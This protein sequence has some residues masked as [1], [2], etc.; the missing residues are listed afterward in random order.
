M[1]R[2]NV[3]SLLFWTVLLLTVNAFAAHSVHYWTLYDKSQDNMGNTVCSWV[4]NQ[5]NETHTVVTSGRG[6]FCPRPG[7]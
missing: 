5:M 7:L 6:N 4:C 2:R 1:K 3:V